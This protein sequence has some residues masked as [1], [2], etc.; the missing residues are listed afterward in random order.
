MRAIRR[1][2]GNS[3]EMLPFGLA[4][5]LVMTGGLV[6]SGAAGGMTSTCNGAF[7]RCSRKSAGVV[8][9]RHPRPESASVTRLPVAQAAP[10]WS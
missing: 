7:V 1:A 4:T 3:C 9:R 6:A 10:D 8:L 2:E 5:I